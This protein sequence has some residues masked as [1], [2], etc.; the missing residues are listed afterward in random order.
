[1]ADAGVWFAVVELDDDCEVG[2][3]EMAAEI[4]DVINVADSSA[5]S[6]VKP[7]PSPRPST[8]CALL[9][10]TSLEAGLFCVIVKYCC[11]VFLSI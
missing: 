1:M 6:E 2:A 11:V 4:A 10:V 8:C 5:C 7:S 3:L 9:S